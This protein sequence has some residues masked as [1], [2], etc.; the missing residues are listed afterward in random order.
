MAAAQ[1]AWR[2]VDAANMFISQQVDT[3]P[4]PVVNQSDQG[5]SSPGSQ[6]QATIRQ[7]AQSNHLRLLD[8]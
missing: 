3:L 5:S 1:V 8:R 6:A 2:W 7:H 4:G